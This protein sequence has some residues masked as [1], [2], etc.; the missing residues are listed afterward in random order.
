MNGAELLV[1]TAV[2]CGVKICF[3]NP[4]T[5]EI[6]IVTALDKVRG[7]KPVMGLFEGVCTGAA[8]GYGRVAMKPAM[9]LL[10]LVPGFANGIACLHNARRC[11]TPVLNVVGEHATWHLQNDPPLAGDLAGLAAVESAWLRTSATTD[12]IG[13]DLADAV[14][15]ARLGRVAT[16]IVPNDLQQAETAAKGVQMRTPE[17]QAIDSTVIDK[18]A[19]LLKKAKKAALIMG[20]PA[21]RASG[22]EA[23]VRVRGISGCDLLTESFPPFMDRGAG[24]PPVRRIPYFPEP[25]LKL[26]A[27]YEAFVLVG[28]QPPVSFFGYP[29]V[30][31]RLISKEQKK[32]DI[33]VED[34]QVVE[35]LH[36]LADALGAPPS[37][38][39]DAAF[40]S[41]YD[42]PVVPS[43]RLTPEKICLTLAAL[44]PE[45]AIIVDEG[46][47]T[48]M[49]YYG[50]SAGAPRH[51]LTTIVGGAIGYG[52]PCALGAALAAPGRKI[53]NLQAD[54]SALYT[55]QALWSQAR[56]GADV[57]T[58]ICSN[59]GYRIVEVELARAGVK[60][61]GP[62]SAELTRF[63]SPPIHWVELSQGFGVPAVSVDSCEDLALE[64]RRAMAAYGPHLIEMRV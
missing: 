19:K 10:H 50:V 53:I 9:T 26:L 34:R 31:G 13:Q 58:L 22:L 2:E 57:T 1:K 4:G 63:K 41:V 55:V 47:T 64:L 49:S 5:T 30:P 29:G 62:A 16:L 46:L 51:S 40:R 38:A 17:A 36:A 39:G 35:A 15:A 11:R 23:A 8:D 12:G 52:M 27:Q 37:D 14:A 59:R 6:P 61:P 32:V 48:A 56:E 33:G 44:Q 60:K 18:A 43:G 54:G 24:L 3:A 20:G 28:A 45:D 7:L 42:R 25:A 21:L